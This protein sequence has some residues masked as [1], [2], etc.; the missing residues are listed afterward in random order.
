MVQNSQHS[1]G[2]DHF[3]FLC[4]PPNCMIMKETSVLKRSATENVCS[5]WIFNGHL[6]LQSLVLPSPVSFPFSSCWKMKE[7]GRGGEK[8][9]ANKPHCPDYKY[10]QKKGPLRCGWC[11]TPQLSWQR[12]FALQSSLRTFDVVCVWIFLH[13][14]SIKI[15]KEGFKFDFFFPH[16]GI[17][18]IFW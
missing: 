12:M 1:G 16:Q 4:F 18:S 15:L 9:Q 13:F 6:L 7:K 17:I 14:E 5:S 8:N 10:R 2:C 3:L 11:E